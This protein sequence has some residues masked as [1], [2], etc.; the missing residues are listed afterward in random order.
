MVAILVLLTIVGFLLVDWLLQAA[1]SWQ[2]ARA[3]AKAEARRRES[4]PGFQAVAER[5]VAS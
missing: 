2:Q 3:R 4:A 5:R 1:R